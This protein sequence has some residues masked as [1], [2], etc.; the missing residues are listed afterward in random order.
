[1]IL[2]YDCCLNRWASMNVFLMFFFP[3]F[4]KLVQTSG[5]Y[6]A[7]RQEGLDL[8]FVVSKEVYLVLST[9]L[10]S[11]QFLLFQ[12]GRREKDWNTYVFLKCLH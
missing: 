2:W 9:A 5:V 11:S 3:P 10:Y 8:S 6:S 4:L 7:Q 1:M 12:A